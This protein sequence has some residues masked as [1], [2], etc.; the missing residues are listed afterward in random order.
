M[1]LNGLSIIAHKGAFFN[2][3]LA[4]TIG[5]PVGNGGP[6]FKIGSESPI[7]RFYPTVRINTMKIVDIIM[8]DD[9]YIENPLCLAQS[10]S[11]LFSFPGDPTGPYL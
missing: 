4:G 1:E 8:T 3:Y 6:Y 10:T 7:F 11:M 5:V 2:T 9:Y